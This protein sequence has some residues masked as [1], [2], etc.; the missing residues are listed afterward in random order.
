MQ[1]YK[2]KTPKL[3]GT[4]WAE[5]SKNAR[6][7]YRAIKSKTKRRPYVRAAYFNKQKIF[8]EL[9]WHHLHEKENLRDK[10]RRVKYFPC[11]LE[12]IQKSRYEP[13]SKENPNKNG[14]TVHRFAGITSDNEVFFVQIKE[15]KRNGE[16][17]LMSV[18]PLDK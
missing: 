11:A 3:P 5:A 6:N 16:K 13:I 4:R 18:F 9:F 14:E 1:A 2:A 17:W 10:T 12:L 15:M 8:L 7:F